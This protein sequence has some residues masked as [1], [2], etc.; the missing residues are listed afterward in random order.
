[1]DTME[2]SLKFTP[3]RLDVK[4]EFFFFFLNAGDEFPVYDL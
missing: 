3:K 1:M 2:E 4:K